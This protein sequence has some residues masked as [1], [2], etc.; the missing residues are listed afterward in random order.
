MDK[1]KLVTANKDLENELNK[2]VSLMRKMGKKE[3]ISE[4]ESNENAL[5]DNS[6]DVN[7]ELDK[8]GYLAEEIID[9][10]FR[11]YTTSESQGVE[12]IL[13]LFNKYASF[14]DVVLDSINKAKFKFDMLIDEQVRENEDLREKID[15]YNYDFT[16]IGEEGICNGET[17]LYCVHKDYRV[18]EWNLTNNNNAFTLKVLDNNSN[19]CEV[20]CIDDN[21]NTAATEI[22]TAKLENGEVH[23]I[24]IMNIGT[25]PTEEE[26]KGFSKETNK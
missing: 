5:M 20:T 2:A 8:A 12:N 13:F 16:I 22:L 18:V 25:M 23:T 11:K 9:N 26:I 14:M 10:Y 6:I 4:V 7:K 21:Y 17:E 19:R 24:E 3:L 15:E 1:E